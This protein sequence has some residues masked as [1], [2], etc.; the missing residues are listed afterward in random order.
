MNKQKLDTDEILSKIYEELECIQQAI[1]R[2][3]KHLGHLTVA[4]VRSGNSES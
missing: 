2:L 3:G 4:I 1:E